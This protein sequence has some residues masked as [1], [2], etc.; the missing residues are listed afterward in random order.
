MV[1]RLR[2]LADTGITLMTLR[3]LGYLLS[4]MPDM[5]ATGRQISLRRQLL[6]GILLPI[7]LFIVV[8]TVSLYRQALEAVNVSPTT[9]HYWLRPRPLAIAEV[10][11]EGD[12]AHRAKCLIPPGGV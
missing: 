10:E 5:P 2:K 7:A 1:Y 6:I 9:A 4:P 11:G 3:G 12:A 8:D